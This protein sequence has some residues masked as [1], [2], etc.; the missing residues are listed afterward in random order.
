MYNELIAADGSSERHWLEVF[1]VCLSQWR[2]CWF[3]HH[4]RGAVEPTHRCGVTV[5]CIH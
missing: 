4:N 5:P 3:H 1:F 2:C